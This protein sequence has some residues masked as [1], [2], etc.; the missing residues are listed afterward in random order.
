M[1]KLLLG[2]TVILLLVSCSPNPDESKIPGKIM[3]LSYV[4]T[5][6]YKEVEITDLRNGEKII[7]KDPND[8]N[9]F[10]NML[11]DIE[12]SKSEDQEV[13][14]GGSVFALQLFSNRTKHLLN[15]NPECM[16]AVHRYALARDKRRLL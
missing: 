14:K 9:V 3:L 15:S 8:V 16:P 7:L 2:L 5:H 11:E 1:E 13:R 10:L 6:L 12:L 4:K